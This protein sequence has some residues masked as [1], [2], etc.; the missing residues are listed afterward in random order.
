MKFFIL[1]VF[2]LFTT[3]S[4]FAER[5]RPIYIA[6]DLINAERSVK[7]IYKSLSVRLYD[8]RWNFV[9]LGRS[10]MSAQIDQKVVLFMRDVKKAVLKKTPPYQAGSEQLFNRFDR[11]NPDHRSLK[12]TQGVL[13][14]VTGALLLMPS[15]PAFF[16]TS[17]GQ[18]LRLIFSK[19][20]SRAGEKINLKKLTYLEKEQ[21]A[22]YMGG[23]LWRLRGGGLLMKR[24]TQANRAWYVGRG[25]TALGELANKNTREIARTYHS[26]L[27]FYGWGEFFDI[28]NNPNQ[29][30][31]THDFVKMT[32][33]G[34]IQVTPA[35]EHVLDLGG[36]TGSL[37]ASGLQMGPCY[38]WAWHE[39]H[40][41]YEKEDVELPLLQFIHSYPTS[42]G[43]VCAG[44]ALGL[45]LLRSLTPVR[46]LA[47]AEF[48]VAYAK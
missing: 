28:G 44:A 23:M 6:P 47:P 2:A 10:D 27:V 14:F 24:G 13:E 15:G 33:R 31:E 22:I 40:G 37:I 16:E 11:Y 42:V 3:E 46:A 25:F 4:A 18:S 38:F 7:S 30:S 41:I 34:L 29:K 12:T 1:C 35:I 48:E 39:F 8:P 21:L 20:R 36:D 9:T 17:T 19:L 32:E 45:G 43:E 5:F 26:Q